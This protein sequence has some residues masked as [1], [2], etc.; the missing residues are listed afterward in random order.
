MGRVDRRYG[1]VEFDWLRAKRSLK[2]NPIDKTKI[3]CRKLLQ[4][5]HRTVPTLEIIKKTQDSQTAKLSISFMT[6][7]LWIPFADCLQDDFSIKSTLRK[8]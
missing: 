4:R 6:K 2:L 1:M 5:M 3:S 8:S 7:L